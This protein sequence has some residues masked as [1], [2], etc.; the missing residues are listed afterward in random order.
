MPFGVSNAP[1]IFRPFM[2]AIFR[3]LITTEHVFIYLDDIL[4]T[5]DTLEELRNYSARVFSVLPD[6]NLTV[7]PLKCEF[8][9]T[10]I[11]YLGIKISQ[12]TIEKSKR[13]CS[14]IDE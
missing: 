14:A 5:P 11:T 9:R 1:A 13:W 10:K 2:D 6:N 12:G 3:I 8:K 4:I 7:N